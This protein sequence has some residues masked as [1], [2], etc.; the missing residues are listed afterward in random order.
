MNN[1]F[2][3]L[4]SDH[5][6][7]GSIGVG[8]RTDTA[9]AS[10]CSSTL[11]RVGSTTRNNINNISSLYIK[12]GVRLCMC[13]IQMRLKKLLLTLVI[14]FFISKCLFQITSLKVVF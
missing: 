3:Y 7:Q 4:F 1:P 2:S 9:H 6:K 8:E 5:S 11:Q 12:L 14:K 10:P 13:M